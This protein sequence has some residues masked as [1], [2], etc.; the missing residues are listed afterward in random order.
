MNLPYDTKLLQTPLEPWS[1]VLE[2]YSQFYAEE[3]DRS[4]SFESYLVMRE[5]HFLPF[6]FLKKKAKLM[7]K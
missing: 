7:L 3:E 6:F 4:K 5:G 2:R 1:Q